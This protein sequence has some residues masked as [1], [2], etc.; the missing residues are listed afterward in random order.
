M[1]DP[2]GESPFEERPCQRLSLQL[3]STSVNAAAA[4]DRSAPIAE[5]SGALCVQ[6]RYIPLDAGLI[7]IYNPTEAPVLGLII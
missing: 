2:V 6:R 1:C 5:M 7:N 3:E 4:R